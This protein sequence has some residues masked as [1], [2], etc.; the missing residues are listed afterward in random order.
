[1]PI[2]G[3]GFRNARAIGLSARIEGNETPQEAHFLVFENDS[4]K[5]VISLLTPAEDVD[6]GAHYE[7]NVSDFGTLIRSFKARN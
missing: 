7:R 5:F 1:M 3:D 4:R 2:V 6:E